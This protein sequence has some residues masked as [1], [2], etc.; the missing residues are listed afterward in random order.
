MKCVSENISYIVDDKELGMATFLYLVQKVWPGNYNIEMTS[1]A[2]HKTVNITAWDEQE[3]VGC[4]RLLTDGYFFGTITE[5]LVAPEYRMRGIGKKLIELTWEISP[6]SLFIGA[7]P[8]KEEFF[9]KHGFTK[10]I[11]S[12]QIKK[13]RKQ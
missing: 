9:E 10:S 6:T 3:L 4:S 13:S 2:I 7:Q 5:I 12:Y 1:E 11:Q 8:G